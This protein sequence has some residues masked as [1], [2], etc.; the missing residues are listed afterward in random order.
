MLRCFA[1]CRRSSEAE[2]RQVLSIQS[3]T[4]ELETL[5]ERWD[6][7]INE[8]FAESRSAKQPGRPIFNDMMRRVQV[9]EADAI[10]CWKLDRLAR[11]PIDAGL[12]IW[13]VNHSGVKIITPNQTYQKDDESVMLMYIELG[14]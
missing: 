1:Y 6:G 8:V 14:M 7:E 12:V 2:D 5:G 9:G 4:T 13:A 11:N 10:L 3:Q